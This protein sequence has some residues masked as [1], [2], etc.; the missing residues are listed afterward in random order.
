MFS[1]TDTLVVREVEY[2]EYDK[3]LTVLTP[4][5]GRLTVSARGARRQGSPHAAATQLLCFGRMVLTE[6]RQRLTLREAAVTESFL[7]LRRDVETMALASYLADLAGALMPEGQA[8]PEMFTLTLR[9]LG[10]LSS[11]GRNPLI[12]KG[13]FELAALCL[14]GYAPALGGC[15]ACGREPVLPALDAVRGVVFCETCAPADAL[16]LTGGV[17]DALRFVCGRPGGKVFSFTLQAGDRALFGRV[18]E[19][20]LLAQLDRPFA[21]LSFYKGLL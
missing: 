3:I 5:H 4:E 2:K 19:R 1:E 6:F 11:G 14:S 21:T 12:V 9:A 16:R 20:Y 10:A 8:A 18:C 13:A 15:A 7:P 17:W